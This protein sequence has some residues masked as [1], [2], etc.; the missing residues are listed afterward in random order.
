MSQI[1]GN[2]KNDDDDNTK[3]DSTIKTEVKKLFKEG[4]KLNSDTVSYLRG[5]YNDEAVIDV[6][7]DEFRDRW[8]LIQTA[9][10]EFVNKFNKKY[11]EENLPLHEVLK[12]A[13]KYKDKYKLN[14]DEFEEVRKIFTGQI[15]GDV[16]K[17]V[18]SKDG[19]YPNT[20]LGRALGSAYTSVNDGIRVSG[21]EDYQHIQEI[22]RSYNLSKSLHSQ[23]IL[24]TGIE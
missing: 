5:K 1:R 18:E 8:E 6:I 17:L 9:A 14:D 22:L 15:F 16:N 20:N 12:L 24:Q 11:G 23:V 19:K 2:P 4:H 10:H 21:N 3:M 13:M 7:L